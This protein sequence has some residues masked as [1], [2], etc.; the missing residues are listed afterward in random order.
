MLHNLEMIHNLGSDG[1]STLLQILD[2]PEMILPALKRAILSLQEPPL[3][4][5]CD[6]TPDA[7]AEIR[8]QRLLVHGYASPTALYPVLL[9]QLSVGDLLDGVVYAGR[10]V[11]KGIVVAECLSREVRGGCVKGHEFGVAGV[12]GGYAV[13]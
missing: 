1:I 7:P 2:V 9:R 3:D 13:C 12:E 8:H 4:A 10:R 11:V 6:S 5:K